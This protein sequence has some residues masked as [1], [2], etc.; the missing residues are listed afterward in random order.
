MKKS[1]AVS[2]FG[3]ATKLGQAVGLSKGRISQWPKVIT[4]LM[5]DAA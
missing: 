3:T 4:D 5:K 1:D 2:V